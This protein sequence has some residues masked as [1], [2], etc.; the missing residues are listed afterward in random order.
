LILE[1]R[2]GMSVDVV[3]RSILQAIDILVQV[4]QLPDRTRRL[5]SV[6]EPGLTPDGQ[7]A[8]AE[9]FVFEQTENGAGR[10]VATGVKPKKV[11]DRISRAGIQI[12]ERIFDQSSRPTDSVSPELQSTIDHQ[13]EELAQLRAQVEVLKGE[14]EALRRPREARLGALLSVVDV[15]DALARYPIA[16][17]QIRAGVAALQARLDAMLHGIGFETVAA[18]GM[19]VDEQSHEIIGEVDRADMTPRSIAAVRKRGFRA[20]G[21]VIRKASVIVAR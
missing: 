21:E 10:W 3:R 9:V 2:A 1:Q 15:A 5:I 14:A 13:A 11:L 16:D 19:T 6:G 17:D 7:Y 4:A 18:P 12:P 20:Q 8:I